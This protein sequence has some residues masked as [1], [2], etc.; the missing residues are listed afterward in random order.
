MIMSESTPLGPPQIPFDMGPDPRA[1]QQLPTVAAL[2]SSY[3]PG[4]HSQHTVDRFL[5]G[6]EYNGQMHY[7]PFRVVSMYVDQLPE[8]DLSAFRAEQYDIALYPDITAA[9]T[10]DTGKLAVDHVLLV[11]ENGD[12]PT[13]EKGQILYPR[14]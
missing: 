7:P 4:S 10:L 5:M 12:Y 9:L 8:N 11:C 2:C 1:G 14:Y 3:F 13:N 6:Y